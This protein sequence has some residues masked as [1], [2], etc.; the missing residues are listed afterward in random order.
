[1]VVIE[2]LE[3]TSFSGKTGQVKDSLVQRP[4]FYLPSSSRTKKFA[5]ISERSEATRL[6]SYARV[7]E[8]H[9]NEK[10]SEKPV[11]FVLT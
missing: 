11:S 6:K 3:H 1:M 9:L 8:S 2:S 10:R 7:S 4:A 5:K